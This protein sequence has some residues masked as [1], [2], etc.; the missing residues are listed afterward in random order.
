MDV[1][2]FFRLFRGAAKFN[3]E[4]GKKDIYLFDLFDLFCVRS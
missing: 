4:D 2:I 3:A 1:M